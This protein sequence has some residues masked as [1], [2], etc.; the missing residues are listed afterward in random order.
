MVVVLSGDI[1]ERLKRFDVMYVESLATLT[2]IVAAYTTAILVALACCPR[3][4]QPIRSIVFGLATS[5]ARGVWPNEMLRCP[6][7][8]A[9]AAAK[10]LLAVRAHRSARSLELYAALITHQLQRPTLPLVVVLSRTFGADCKR[11][12]LAA[13]KVARE[14]VIVVCLHH[15]QCAAVLT[16][17]GDLIALPSGT[18]WPGVR[19]GFTRRLARFRAVV[20]GMSFA[21]ARIVVKLNL[22]VGTNKALFRHWKALL[23]YIIPNKILLVNTLT[24]IL[25]DKALIAELGI[26]DTDNQEAQDEGSERPDGAKAADDRAR[27]LLLEL[28]LLSLEATT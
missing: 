14:A 6:I 3:L 20:M 5:P 21:I 24:P 25:A 9:L 4:V 8:F 28:D 13:A 23:R 12:A 2:L 22:T 10:I 7:A 11:L 27:A 17:R 19:H 18:I 26:D 15:E 1:A 16:R